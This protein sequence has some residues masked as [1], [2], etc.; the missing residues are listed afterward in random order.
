ME[1]HGGWALQATRASLCSHHRRSNSAGDR[2]SV[3]PW[4]RCW[5][6]QFVHSAVA[7]E[8]GAHALRRTR[9]DGTNRPRGRVARCRSRRR[10][11]KS[12]AVA[13]RRRF[14][15]SNR[16]RAP[17][18]DLA[19]GF[20]NPFGSGPGLALW[21]WR[22]SLGRPRRSVPVAGLQRTTPEHLPQQPQALSAH[23]RPAKMIWAGLP[24]LINP[25][26]QPTLRRGSVII[27]P[28]DEHLS[29]DLMNR[30]RSWLSHLQSAVR[31]ALATVIAGVVGCGSVP[32]LA[33]AGRAKPIEVS[34]SS[35]SFKF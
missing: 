28:H 6:H 32:T 29:R 24:P 34:C 9:L 23:K 11:D 19:Y 5:F 30:L 7:Q 33:D 21:L 3:A 20:A 27:R 17:S 12:G 22:P 10:G 35:Y 26:L 8:V 25:A 14:P 13:N 16:C 4:S 1:V 31:A 2:L 18:C 15:D